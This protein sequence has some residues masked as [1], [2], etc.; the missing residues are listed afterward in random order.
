M[1]N[2]EKEGVWK[3]V[4]VSG[5]LL[6]SS[7]CEVGETVSFQAQYIYLF[8]KAVDTENNRKNCCAWGDVATGGCIKRSL[9]V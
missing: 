1:K 9:C 5:F 8:W 2:Q 3:V 7:E 4:R 6:S